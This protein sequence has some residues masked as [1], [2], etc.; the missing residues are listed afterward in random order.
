MIQIK[1]MQI[2]DNDNR[3]LLL[4]GG[5]LL[6]ILLLIALVIFVGMQLALW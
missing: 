6:D 1:L 4:F 5:M 3:L 2:I